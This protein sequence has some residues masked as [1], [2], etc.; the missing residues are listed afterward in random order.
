[1]TGVDE[2][3]RDGRGVPGPASD[4]TSRG[5]HVRDR[6]VVVLAA[7]CVAVV[8][9]LQLL[10]IIYPPCQFDRAP[11]GLPKLTA[12]TGSKQRID[13][14][15]GLLNA[16][17]QHLEVAC[18]RRVNPL[19]AGNRGQ[20]VPVARRVGRAG[21]RFAR[22]EHDH[23]ANAGS[24]EEPGRDASVATVV[25]GS[26][27]H[28]HEPPAGPSRRLEERANRCGRGGAGLLHEPAS[29]RAHELRLVIG[30]AHLLARHG[31][32]GG[33]LVPVGGERVEVE[34]LAPQHGIISG[35][36]RVV[37]HAGSRRGWRGG[38]AHGQ[39]RVPHGGRK[40]VPGR[41][42]RGRARPASRPWT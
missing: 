19:D 23:D 1:M 15:R 31:R 18:L 37:G 6:E 35:E 38:G 40:R 22:H 3:G 33:G 21:P 17:A 5:H 26:D 36:R 12:D 13:D 30:A 4:P 24:R 7:F 8:L 32:P 25:A 11:D 27:Q 39:H 9:G 29:G 28:Q 34:R 41:S 16:L 42:R 20:G 2:A 10:G 14:H